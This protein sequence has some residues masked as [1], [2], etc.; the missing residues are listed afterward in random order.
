[1]RISASILALVL[2]VGVGLSC[3]LAERLTSNKNISSVNELWSDVPPYPGATKTNLELPMPA[4]IGLRL[5][6]DGQMNYIGFSTD[7][8]VVEV[9][10]Y[11]SRTRMLEA[12]WAQGQKDCTG[13]PDDKK[14]PSAIC[15]FAREK[16]D[17]HSDVLAI[18]AMKNDKL[19][20]TNI[21]YVRMDLPKD[22][23]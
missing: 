10:D 3:K 9:R 20:E 8:S 18:V 6:M 13:N 15:V 4:R 12:G 19:P 21:F 14:N 22:K 2:I 1:M 11:Y 17:T 23:K 16:N 7:K 5:V